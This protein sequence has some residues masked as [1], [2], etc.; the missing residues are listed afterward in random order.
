MR[1]VEFHIGLADK[2]GYACRLL[3]KVHARGLRAVV[4]GEPEALSRLD[5][6]LWTFDVGDFIPHA[7]L[8]RGEAPPPLL[9]RTPIWLADEVVDGLE[10]A[11]LV[12]LGPAMPHRHA[13]FD[14][15]IELVAEA[16][17]DLA[18]GRQ[19]WRQYKAAGDQ[20]RDVRQGAAPAA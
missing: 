15:V 5:V 1:E 7:R 20:P 10:A 16:E 11:V 3:R 2:P 12:N 9:A 14:R 8:R 4:T 6:L 18:A 19:R 17:D 13:G